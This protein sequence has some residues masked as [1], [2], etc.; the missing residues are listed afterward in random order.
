MTNVKI[1]FDLVP[2][3]NLNPLGFELWTNAQRVINFTTVTDRTAVVYECDLVDGDHCVDLVLKNKLPEHTTVSE[4]GEILSDTTIAIENFSIDDMP[5]NQL[6]FDNSVYTHSFN[7]DQAL[8]K[9]K[10][11]G[12]M[13]C[14]GTVRL[15]FTTPIYLWLLE[16]M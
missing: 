5:L 4:S 12:T 13:G 8:V 15:T 10:F 6:L 2:S 1:S 7:S 3:N 16:R 11:Y 14:N 9:D